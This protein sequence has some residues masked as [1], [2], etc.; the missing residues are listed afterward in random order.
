V[1]LAMAIVPFVLAAACGPRGGAGGAHGGTPGGP[2]PPVGPPV[3]ESLAER[4]RAVHGEAIVVDGHND[5]ALAIVDDGFDLGNDGTQGKPR[6]HTDLRR[7][8]AG[9]LGAVFFAIYVDGRF[10]PKQP[11]ERSHAYARARAMIAAV[12]AQTR[13][14]GDRLELA[15]TAADVA[16]IKQR[17]KV[18][19]LLGL[20]GGHAIENSLEKLQAFH[21][22]GVRYMTLTH[23]ATTEW[24]DSAGD[25]DDPT[26]AHHGGLTDFGRDVVREMNRLGMLVDVSHVADR[27]FFDVLATSRAPVIASHSS[28]RAMADHPRNLSDD[29]LR[30]LR[31]NGGVVMINFFD[32]FLDRRKAEV[33]KQSPAKRRELAARYPNDPAR[34]GREVE[35]WWASHGFPR[36][37]LATLAD[38]ISHAVNVAG[39]DHVG[40]GSDFD[41][42]PLRMVPEGVDD[43]AGFPNITLELMRR[44]HS[45]DDV[46]RILGG[47]LLRV[48]AAA[49][50]LAAKSPSK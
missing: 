27:T 7:L 31:R 39:V 40:L 49:E 36:T 19:V 17:G 38:H 45:A 42:V 2:T 22:V 18:A 10:L 5:I 20:E 6:T 50:R 3:T 37:P 24:A 41:G 15:T 46:T 32:G 26:V 34:V 1:K 30:A 16:R 4:A 21:A 14:H 35:A 48:M 29:M 8:K 25:M 28:V 47:N 13:A 44:G 43:V 23:W 33:V 11:G 12:Q 9:G